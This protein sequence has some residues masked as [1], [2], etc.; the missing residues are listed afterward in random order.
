MRTQ[1]PHFKYRSKDPAQRHFG[2]IEFE[3]HV[4]HWIDDLEDFYQAFGFNN[5]MRKRGVL[6]DD[7][8]RE[9]Y[10]C[11]AKGESAA[12]FQVHVIEYLSK[13]SASFRNKYENQYKDWIAALYEDISAISIICSVCKAN[14]TEKYDSGTHLE[15]CH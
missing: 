7:F 4:I 1:I 13:H 5:D 15:T 10:L 12:C 8:M 3:G 9:E 11:G 2:L 6:P 14:C